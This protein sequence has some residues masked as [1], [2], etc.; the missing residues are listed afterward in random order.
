MTHRKQLEPKQY[1]FNLNDHIPLNVQVPLLCT[2]AM[3]YAKQ[4]PKTIFSEMTAAALFHFPKIGHWDL[5]IETVVHPRKRSYTSAI[6][7]VRLNSG[8]WCTNPYDTLLAF[9]RR[10]LFI[11][12]VMAISHCLHYQL[13]NLKTLEE[14]LAA[15]KSK[16]GVA[17]VRRALAY[18]SPH[19]ETALET[20]VRIFLYREGYVTFD[21]QVEMTMSNGDKRRFDFYLKLKN[22]IIVIEADGKG[23]YQA[24]FEANF[25][26][27]NLKNAQMAE[28]GIQF[29]HVTWDDVYFENG[30]RKLLDDY[31]VPK[32]KRVIT[33][34]VYKAL[35]WLRE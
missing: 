32:T 4:V 11:S 8:L 17:L 21:Q 1:A 18:A 23:K 5:K 27:E 13:V 34:A 30:F 6:R 16:H 10:E 22:R 25:Q 33:P 3:H 24:D 29:L 9:A 26:R 15:R 12:I 14:F 35:S 7:Y 31:Q 20:L 19:D 28:A 2:L